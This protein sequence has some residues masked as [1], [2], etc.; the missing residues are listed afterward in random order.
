MINIDV[1]KPTG[2]VFNVLFNSPFLKEGLAKERN[3]RTSNIFFRIFRTAVLG[4]ILYQEGKRKFKKPEVDAELEILAI[5]FGSFMFLLR[6]AY[7]YLLDTLQNNC[8]D[9]LPSSFNKFVKAIKQGRYPEIK[10]R[11]GNTSLVLLKF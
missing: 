3:L 10:G 8:K 6:S 5:F 11:F 2:P 1:S 4:N 9:E 7:D